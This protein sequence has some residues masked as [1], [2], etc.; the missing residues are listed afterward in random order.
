M[1]QRLQAGVELVLEKVAQEDKEANLAEFLND[2]LAEEQGV[3]QV[4]KSEG[5]APSSN[6][7]EGMEDKER[8]TNGTGPEE[9]ELAA[10]DYE[11]GKPQNSVPKNNITSET[12]MKD[13]SLPKTASAEDF[14]ASYKALFA[15]K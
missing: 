1:D 10:A 11:T 5:H 12:E 7:S 8:H 14:L 13:L 6:S 3:E 9:E 15:N 4:R 2:K